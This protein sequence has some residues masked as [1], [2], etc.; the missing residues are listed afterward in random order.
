MSRD[1]ISVALITDHSLTNRSI[2]RC[3]DQSGFELHA[4]PSE[5]PQ[6]IEKLV[7]LNPALIFLRATLK[8]QSGFDICEK[9]KSEPALRHSRII[10]LSQDESNREKAIEHGTN[11]FLRMPISAEETVRIVDEVAQQQQTILFVD[12]GKLQHEVVVPW[13]ADEGYD[14]LEAWNGEE[15]LEIIENNSIDLVITDLEMPIM[16]GYQ[17]CRAV[18]SA[19]GNSGPPVLICSSLDSDDD[20]QKGFDCG[21]DDYIVKPVVKIELL[22]RVSRLTSN[23]RPTRLEKIL[24]V[25]DSDLVRQMIVQAI[26]AQGLQFDEARNGQEALEKLRKGNYHL[27]T[28][29]YEMP[30]LNG[31]QLCMQMREDEQTA[32]L[33]IV[34]GGDGISRSLATM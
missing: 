11:H 30:V 16:K 31:Y 9:I 26:S 27:L 32:E 12:D 14:V 25:E 22:S 1:R 17:L 24:V 10:F 2:A 18:K 28:V 13:L 4:L 20:V 34:M 6:L 15:A 19:A 21:A 3:L 5:N 33:P 8:A 23:N 7:E 29:D